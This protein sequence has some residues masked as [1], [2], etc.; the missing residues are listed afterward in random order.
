MTDAIATIGHNSTKAMTVIAEDPG[1]IYRDPDLLEKAVKEYEAELSTAAI[2]LTTTKGRDE[3][4][5]RSAEFSR[6]KVKIED[7]GKAL[8]EEWRKKTAEVNAVKSEVSKAFDKLRD[9]AR[10]PLTEWETAKKK[11][12]DEIA[13]VIAKIDNM[14]LVAADASAQTVRDRLDWLSSLAIDEAWF[15]AFE[16][17]AAGKR[18][19]VTETLTAAL[20]RIEQAERDRAELDRLRAEQA[21]RDR[22]AKEAA[23]KAAAEQAEK[24][25]IANA[26]TKAI[27]DERRRAQAEIDS[28]NARADEIKRQADDAER[29]RIAE[30]RRKDDAEAAQKAADEARQKDIEHR[31]KIM[32]EAKEAI[33]EHGGVKEDAA[34]KIVLAIVAGSISHASIRF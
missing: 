31:G 28:A 24:D 8:T 23:D 1:A 19:R 17:I 21:E 2:D 12:D 16:P 32:R 9:D 30:Q 3:I 26:A 22:A 14:A 18:A 33:M 11:R 6:L 34:K 27:D 7:A 5:S 4:K 13:A 25:R 15:G 29:A 10:R 20:S